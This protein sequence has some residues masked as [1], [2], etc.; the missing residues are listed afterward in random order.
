M[1]GST[2]TVTAASM[3]LPLLMV[4]VLPL[5]LLL[6]NFLVLLQPPHH[7]LAEKRCFMAAPLLLGFP[8]TAPLYTLNLAGGSGQRHGNS[9]R[10]QCMSI[11]T[12]LLCCMHGVAVYKNANNRAVVALIQNGRSKDDEPAPLKQQHRLSHQHGLL[13]A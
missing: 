6:L 12:E 8:F 1:N 4:L 10:T 5:R 13:P 3:L 11:A 7:C 9:D 2:H